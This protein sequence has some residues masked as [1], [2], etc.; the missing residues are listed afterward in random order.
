MAKDGIKKIQ[1]FEQAV[2]KRYREGKL[3]VPEMTPTEPIDAEGIKE[4]KPKNLAESK[5]MA[6]EILQ[7]QFSG[8]G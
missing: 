5:K 1:D 4:L 3:E 6:T 2:I 8:R 7:K